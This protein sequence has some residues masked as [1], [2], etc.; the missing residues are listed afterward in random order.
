LK[1]EDRK[2]PTDLKI[3]LPI[4]PKNKLIKVRNQIN[5]TVTNTSS[6]GYVS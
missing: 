4:S 5:H 1:N 2:E 6:T 3:T